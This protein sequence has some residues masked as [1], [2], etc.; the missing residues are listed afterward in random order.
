MNGNFLLD[1]GLRNNNLIPELVS[2]DLLDAGE[3]VQA[4]PDSIL[5]YYYTNHVW[6]GV[7]SVHNQDGCIICACNYP[8]E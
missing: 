7:A 2:Q 6:I 5:W 4:H 8:T 3:W 1:T